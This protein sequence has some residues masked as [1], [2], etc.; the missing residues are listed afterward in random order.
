[1]LTWS[2]ERG[3][4]GLQRLA[5]LLHRHSCRS[6]GLRL[7]RV[8]ASRQPS[9]GGVVPPG[10]QRLPSLDAI[11]LRAGVHLLGPGGQVKS[12]PVSRLFAQSRQPRLLASEPGRVVAMT[13]AAGQ[14][15]GRACADVEPMA[16]AQVLGQ[17]W[18]GRQR[19]GKETCCG[20][21]VLLD[22]AV[23]GQI[24]AV[25]RGGLV[26][27]LD[28]GGKTNFQRAQPQRRAAV[29]PPGSARESSCPKARRAS[30]DRGRVS[31]SA[32]R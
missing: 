21:V 27:A 8:S 16:G 18:C 7:S 19:L 15:G 9:Q 28:D 10:R 25:R 24:K 31:A 2:F 11:R 6:D 3:G 30:R 17:S 5:G 32:C 13:A 4:V 23:F 29:G 14:G 26:L 20:G 1:M 22:E 12:Q